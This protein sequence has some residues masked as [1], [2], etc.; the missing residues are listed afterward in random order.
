MSPHKERVAGRPFLE[1]RLSPDGLCGS[2]TS[3]RVREGEDR[4]PGSCNMFRA[5]RRHTAPE[6]RLHFGEESDS[7]LQELL[8]EDEDDGEGDGEDEGAADTD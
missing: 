4:T 5:L 8:V 7:D 2:D 3:Q 1:T 6:L